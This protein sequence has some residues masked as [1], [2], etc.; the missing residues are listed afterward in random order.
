MPYASGGEP[1]DR[2][3]DRE[4][5]GT[6]VAGDSDWAE[7]TTSVARSCGMSRRR[8]E[9][10]HNSDV[11]IHRGLDAR[12]DGH[13]ARQRHHPHSGT[14]A[15]DIGGI[16]RGHTDGAGTRRRIG[17]CSRRARPEQC[18]EPVNLRAGWIRDVHSPWQRRTEHRVLVQ[19]RD[20]VDETRVT[21]AE[22]G[23]VMQE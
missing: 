16:E 7:S 21:R 17:T 13:A 1:L 5:T 11:S 3:R 20:Q 8:G 22:S 23:R 15:G 4:N 12:Q 14:G 19:L 9:L 18:A 2:V 10:R 6:P